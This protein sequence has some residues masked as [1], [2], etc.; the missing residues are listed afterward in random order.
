M[1]SNTQLFLLLAFLSFASLFII[2]CHFFLSALRLLFFAVF[3]LSSSKFA[4]LILSFFSHVLFH[5]PLSLYSRSHFDSYR[6][7][8][9]AGSDDRFLSPLFLPL[10]TSNDTL[11]T[12]PISSLSN[13]PLPLG[14]AGTVTQ[15]LPFTLPASNSPFNH[16]PFTIPP[17]LPLPLTF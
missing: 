4:F 5:L 11:L 3:F 13:S 14:E 8:V 10:N 9:K 1:S 17:S 16:V 12:T 6:D 2:G 15:M 7:L